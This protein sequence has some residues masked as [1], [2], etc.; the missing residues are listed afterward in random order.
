MGFKKYLAVLIVALQ[1]FCAKAQDNYNVL[2]W[3][4]YSSLNTWLIQ[5]VHQQYSLRDSLLKKAL[6][7]KE[8]I[9]KYRIACRKRYLSILGKL[10]S[11]TPLNAS[12]QGVI[13]EK[14][15]HIEKIVF[16]SSPNY[17]V[18]A[19]LYLTSKKGVYP[20]VIFLC[21]HESTA[22]AT[23]S[24]QKTAQLFVK[25][26]FVVMMIDPISQGERYQIVDSLGKPA[27]RGGTTEHTLL[28]AG[29]NLV[30]TSVA[31]YEL[32]DNIRSIDYLESR[33]EVD[34]NRIGCIGNSG[35]GTQTTYLIAFDERIKIAAPCSYVAIRERN[36]ELFG[37]SDGCQH[38]P[39]EGRVMLEIEDFLI[40]SAPK[41][42]L[43]LAGKFDFVDFNGVK[44][45]EKDLK[46]VYSLYNKPSNFKLFSWDDGHGISKHKREEAVTFF[47]SFLYNDNSMVIEQESE[48]LYENL[49]KCTATGQVV[50]SYKDEKTIQGLNL[51][52]ANRLAANR[53]SFAR[54]N[55][56]TRID[57]ISQLIGYTNEKIVLSSEIIQSKEFE[58]FTFQKLIIRPK[59]EIPIPCLVY[60]P[61]QSNQHADIEII[62]NEDGKDKVAASEIVLNLIKTGKIVVIPDLRGMGETFDKSEQNDPKYWNKEYRNAM[63]S[64]HIGKT[65]TGQR[66]GDLIAIIQYFNADLKDSKRSIAINA[67]GSYGPIA[68]YAGL[69]EKSIKTINIEGSIKSYFELLE[70]PL[71]KDAYTHVIHSVLKYYDLPDIVKWAGTERFKIINRKNDVKN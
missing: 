3:K 13:S 59:N 68:M 26:G 21:G 4:G 28:N 22:K 45:V 27:T 39:F 6:T 25:N 38:I 70:N 51:E 55:E 9:E 8:E 33:P 24:Y 56:Q 15:Y 62:L 5:Q 31:A 35:G 52:L 43:I 29:A 66:V 46:Q 58:F 37:A 17:H 10:P 12:T 23:E 69:F 57:K 60:Y 30:G 47:R 53:D 50:N 1:L 41:P 67:K 48:V 61:K 34:K 2:P 54:L 19:N 65:L 11:K 42:L 64:L 32:W 14:E 20:A 16:E 49:L 44:Q 36:L 18:T 7:S 71:T 63:I 40:A